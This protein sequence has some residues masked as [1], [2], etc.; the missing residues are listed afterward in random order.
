MEFQSLST[1]N[2]LT[3]AQRAALRRGNI[4]TVADLMILNLPDVMKKCRLQMQDA[5]DLV[6]TVRD[7]LHWR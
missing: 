3:A 6:D 1:I 2:V 5:Q 4:V 7:V